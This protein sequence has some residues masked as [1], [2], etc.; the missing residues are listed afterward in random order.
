MSDTNTAS[1]SSIKGG[2]AIKRFDDIVSQAEIAQ[3]GRIIY[4]WSYS[5]EN[6]NV[7]A[8]TVTKDKQGKSF[9]LKEVLVLVQ[10]NFGGTTT[11][12]RGDV[13]VASQSN[14][15]RIQLCV[16][17]EMSGNTFILGKSRVFSMNPPKYIKPPYNN[18]E[19]NP[20]S[21]AT[22][23]IHS[24]LCGINYSVSYDSLDGGVRDLYVRPSSLGGYKPNELTKPIGF[25]FEEGKES[26]PSE[27]NK[28]IDNRLYMDNPIES[29]TVTTA[30]SGDGST[31]NVGPYEGDSQ[32]QSNI[33]YK[34]KI[35]GIDY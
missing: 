11:T 6:P 31:I 9:K 13:L 27:L 3:K 30:Y 24:K 2:E 34:I 12:S 19:D 10:S 35:Y 22:Y 33:Y 7:G 17:T 21:L 4:E 8:V 16:A 29:I 1:T 32:S 15:L 20:S 5:T 14:P 26:N 28:F 25:T 23:M 18:L